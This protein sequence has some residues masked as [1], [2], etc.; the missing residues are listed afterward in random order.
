MSSECFN[1]IL[2][3]NTHFLRHFVSSSLPSSASVDPLLDLD[4]LSLVQIFPNSGKRQYVKKTIIVTKINNL[5]IILKVHQ[6]SSQII[7]TNGNK[8]KWNHTRWKC[9]KTIYWRLMSVENRRYYTSFCQM[10][11][12]DDKVGSGFIYGNPETFFMSEWNRMT[13][14]LGLCFL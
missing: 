9:I 6:D 2:A 12:W 3:P 5:N 7:Q 13:V 14:G 1:T 4:L 10:T 8:I 11:K